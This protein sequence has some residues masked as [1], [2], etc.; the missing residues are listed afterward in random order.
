MTIRSSN[1]FRP[2]FTVF[3]H[4]AL[5]Q[6]RQELVEQHIEL[7]GVIAST[8]EQARPEQ[9]SKPVAPNDWRGATGLRILERLSWA[10]YL[11]LANEFDSG[12]RSR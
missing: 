2:G 6:A 7:I 10:P 1:T 9:R 12:T 4:S 5:F 8:S 3:G 11:T